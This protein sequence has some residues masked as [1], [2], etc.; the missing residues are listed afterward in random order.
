MKANTV[1]GVEVLVGLLERALAVSK[2][3]ANNGQELTEDSLNQ[4]LKQDASLAGKHSDTLAQR[5]KQLRETSPGEGA[6][7]G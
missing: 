3:L 1:A 5:Q 7:R 6:P 2:A 4:I